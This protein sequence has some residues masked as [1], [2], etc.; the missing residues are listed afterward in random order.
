VFYTESITNPHL[1]IGPLDRVVA[2]SRQH[3]LVT[4][5]DNTLA[6]PMCFRPIEMGYDLVLHS[7]SKYLNGH[8][9]VVA[10]VVAGSTEAVERVRKL[11]NLQGVCLD[12]HA[13]FLLQRGLKTLPVRMEAQMACALELAQFLDE[14]DSV[15]HV[16]HPGLAGTPTHERATE[17]FDG[18]GAMVTFVPRGGIDVAE[19]LIHSLELADIAPSMGG[20][21]TLVCRPST[22]SH[23]G[24][25]PSLRRQMGVEEAMVRVSVGLEDAR[26][27]CDDF[28]RALDHAMRVCMPDEQTRE[29]VT[30]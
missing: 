29:I 18:F 27:V 17:W 13:C 19:T 23:A 8:S 6:T 20:V 10:G 11:A 22:T 26:D 1:E 14:H 16:F 15:E 4:M 9:D 2:L 5:I 3:G 21:E 7:A 12:P 30:H 28:A 25:S 24:L